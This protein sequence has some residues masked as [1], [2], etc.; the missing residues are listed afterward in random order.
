MKKFHRILSAVTAMTL[1]FTMPAGAVSRNA[2][3]DKSETDPGISAFA[4]NPPTIP[5][6][7]HDIYV[8]GNPADCLNASGQ[9]LY[10]LNYNG[11]IYVPL[12]TAAQWM[13]KNVA[14]STD[15]KTFSLSGSKNP[16]YQETVPT[17]EESPGAA[18][19]TVL[20]GAQ[21]RLDG[22]TI[23]LTSATGNNA[24]I[25]VCGGE[26]YLP[27]RSVANVLG[28]G[29]TYNKEAIYM[30]TPL[31]D[32]QLNACKAY[33]DALSGPSEQFVELFGYEQIYTKNLSQLSTAMKTIEASRSY[34]QTIRNE[35]RPDCKLLSAYYA[36]LDYFANQV[37]EGCDVAE[38]L[39]RE[40]APF[41][42]IRYVMLFQNDTGAISAD[43]S[44]S[45][46]TGCARMILISRKI[47]HVVYET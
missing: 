15:G 2:A 42:Q 39:I 25:I 19:I 14:Q 1:A 31:T 4:A 21:L 30:R 28:M 44:R 11:S 13:G 10:P 18:A 43:T 8:E 37:L 9:P 12:L 5:V 41:E 34:A 33:A 32:E 40:N 3:L 38:Q 20:S 46:M 23:D 27:I 47:H 7:N 24:D 45:V 36:D 22:S 17:G 35:T 16:V 26:P 29:L 6:W